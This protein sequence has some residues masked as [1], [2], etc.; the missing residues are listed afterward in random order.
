MGVSVGN[1]IL[2]WCSEAVKRVLL[3]FWACFY[4]L[5]M[6]NNGW[7]ME[8]VTLFT[9]GNLH[10]MMS[11]HIDEPDLHKDPGE[12]DLH[13]DPGEE[14]PPLPSGHD[15]N[16]RTEKWPMGVHPDSRL[17]R[18]RAKKREESRQKKKLEYIATQSVLQRAVEWEWEDW[19]PPGEDDERGVKRRREMEDAEDDSQGED[20]DDWEEDDKDDG[21]DEDG[22]QDEDYLQDEDDW[23]WQDKDC[24][25]EVSWFGFQFLCMEIVTVIVISHGTIVHV[26]M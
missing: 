24:G 4:T 7:L 3:A 5:C 21:D 14:A 18:F 10:A 12:E 11:R 16:W 6:G 22:K 8:S 17:G 26:T 20:K 15:E 2:F 19:Q 25:Q 23:N 13:E 9:L 1:C